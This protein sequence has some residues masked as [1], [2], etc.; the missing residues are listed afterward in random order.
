VDPLVITRLLKSTPSIDERFTIPDLYIRKINSY[1]DG[2]LPYNA[3]AE[4]VHMLGEKYF[5]ELK[6]TVDDALLAGLVSRT[7]QGKSWYHAGVSLGKKSAE[8]EETL[9]QAI[10]S[11]LNKYQLN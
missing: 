11:I 1:L 9:R 2:T 6:F 10:R 5:K 8:V 7:F 3:V 4:A